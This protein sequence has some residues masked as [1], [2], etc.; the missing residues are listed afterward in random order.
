[1][2]LYKDKQPRDFLVH[3]LVAQAFCENKDN[4]QVVNHIDG[5][6]ANNHYKNLEWCSQAYNV[7]HAFKHDLMGTNKNIVLKSKETGDCIKFQSM[8]KVSQ[9]LGRYKGYVS[10][11]LKKGQY[12]TTHYEIIPV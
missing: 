7:R 5:D 3:R 10:G 8:S 1:M 11:L 9:F 6:C 2:T 12:E 4:F